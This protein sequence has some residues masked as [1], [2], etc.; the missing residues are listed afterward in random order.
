MMKRRRILLSV[1]LAVMLLGVWAWSA[2]F[3]AATSTDLRAGGVLVPLGLR[4][5]DLRGAYMDSLRHLYDGG[6]LHWLAGAPPLSATVHLPSPARAGDFYL[7]PGEA[8]TSTA[9]LYTAYSLSGT[10]P[11][12]R[13][14]ALFPAHVA[15]WRSTVTVPVAVDAGYVVAGWEIAEIRQVFDDALM[16]AV[17]Y[18]V[19]TEAQMADRLPAYDVLILPAFRS[20]ARDAVVQRL[21][22]G[23]AFTAWRD[24]VSRGG[25]IL[26]QG[27]AL[28]LLEAAGIFP[29]GTVNLDAPVPL[30][31]EDALVNRGRLRLRQPDSPLAYSWLTDTLYVLDDPLI[32]PEEPME[33]VAE[34]ANL[35]TE[36]V[37]PAL[38]RYPV[39][40][41]GQVIGIVGHPTDPARR[42]ELPLFMDA[43]LLACAGQ[44]DFYGDA[45]QTFNPHYPS[46]QIPLYESVP[47]SASLVVENLWDAPLT[48][49]RVT[50]TVAGGYT[51]L[52]A[53][54][55]PTPTRLMTTAA[56]ETVLLW[57]WPDLAAHQVTTLTYQAVTDPQVL[58]AGEGTF[59]RGRLAY[60]ATDGRPVVISHR[61]FRLT[62]LMAARL[63]GDRD[64]EADRHYIIPAQG[65]Y[66]D[67][68]FSLENKEETWARNLQ[69]TD[70]VL[71]LMPFV[72]TADQHVILSA[73]YG[74]TIWMRNEP[75]LWGAKY[76]L[77][78]G[79]TA[80][81][82]T[83][84]LADW[85]ALPPAE[86]PRCV[87]TSPYGIHIDP[88]LYAHTPITDYGSFIT[89]PPTYT[90]AITVTADHKL[91]LPCMP[92]RWD[93]GDFPPYWYEEPAVRFGIHSRELFGR[94][95][96]FHGTPREGTVVMPY[97]GGSLYVLAGGNPI[98]YD[99]YLEHAAAYAPQPPTPSALT[100]QD[101]WSRTHQ[102]ELRGSFYDVWDWDSCAT[103][104]GSGEQHAGIAITY[105]MWIDR[106]GDGVAETF[107]RDVPT[108]FPQTSLHI[109]GK[110]YSVA[111]AGGG[112]IPPGENLV[113]LPIFHGRGIRIRPQNEGWVDSYRSLAPGN[114][115]LI[116][117]THTAAY[118]TLLFHQDIP[119]GSSAAFA[120]TATMIP[121][122]N[123]NREGTIKIHDGGR[124]VYRQIAAGENRYEV[125]DSHV[126]APEGVSTD[127]EITKQGGPTLVS[128]YSDTLTFIYT[129][130]DRYD[131]RDF[132]SMYDPFFKS[133]GYDDL[134]WSVYVGGREQKTLFHS[135]VGAGGRTRIRVSLDNNT[136]VKLTHIQLIPE[137]PPGI[138]VTLLYTDPNTAPEPIWPELDFLNQSTVPDA[139]RSVWYFEVTVGNVPQSWWGT[140]I[141]IPFR[142]TADNFPAR[143]AYDEIPAARLALQRSGS[144]A[145]RTVS[146]AA[147]SVVLTDTLPS[148]VVLPEGAPGLV[149]TDTAA[150]R[151]LMGALDVDAGNVVSDTAGAF[152]A[153]LVPTRATAI[154]YVLGADGVLTFTLPA[155]LQHL[156][157]SG[158]PLYLVAQTKILR[159][160]HGPNLVNRGAGLSYTDPLGLVW[161][162]HTPPVTVEA[163]GAAV[164]VDYACD[165]GWQESQ[166]PASS[167]VAGGDGSCYIPD[168]GPSEVLIDVTAHN[169][170]DAIA[171]GVTMT[172]TLPDWVSA[173]TATP[174]W[175]EY[176]GRAVTWS[177][178]DLAPGQWKVFTIVLYVDPADG[179]GE[180]GESLP[181]IWRSDGVFRD[182]Y[183]HQLVRGQ[184]GDEFALRIYAPHPR[185]LVYLPLSLRNYDRLPDLQVL[186][187][188][189]APDNAADVQITI[190]NTG[191]SVARAF[192]VDVSLDPRVP[193]EVNQSCAELGCE[194]R[195]S[196]FVDELPAGQ[197]I[198]LKQGDAYEDTSASS[199]PVTY[200]LGTHTIWGY[201]D[202]WGGP[203]PWGG[204]REHDEHN[205]RSDPL[206]FTVP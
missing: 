200:T 187:L 2:Q 202:S 128:I 48:D 91:L 98:P 56:G 20:S 84:T 188:Q 55:H 195:L 14:Y 182:E 43:L 64:I 104:G 3:S 157:A 54:I 191:R 76:P 27:S 106:D 7:P 177:L 163:H 53:T 107:V 81:T 29:A 103:C 142:V 115:T 32:V 180:A 169:A 143:M 156:P 111:Q 196:W 68:A 183:S 58:A 15:V 201:V 95:V 158:S 22:S 203:N 4:Q 138:T 206:T 17:P 117:V 31:P 153:S 168:Y 124:L 80:P 99:A 160:Q 190:V 12:S 159:A 93:L 152:L 120:I 52:T 112:T 131:P 171:R 110:T 144:P 18:D 41:G 166:L 24:F 78:E 119:L 140:V 184:V 194:Y 50:E 101:V 162:E 132:A 63:V 137:P 30:L 197:T 83:L 174:P 161:R 133:W 40:T 5:A 39:G 113:A 145:P 42:D 65:V 130:Q 164:W 13:A 73:N 173:T 49:V 136:G 35:D 108:R 151:D 75:F 72:D 69:H 60:T 86:R 34:F 185:Y 204:V 150:I 61:P 37:Y 51:V 38:I 45:V 10:L 135:V 16:G 149:T 57:S 129:I 179:G 165:G 176:A 97:D 36:D 172:L 105:G 19:L 192:W 77:W 92:L 66:L 114:S 118:D 116:S 11:L 170:G 59:S 88:P 121:Y 155:S 70:W 46:H 102:L 26:A 167:E 141:T 154:D 109:L 47:L 44:A 21:Q 23:G 125:Y 33:V 71:L 74:E 94:E 28:Y 6:R 82:Q 193:P 175:Q 198:T 146:G 79:A 178:G 123:V 199:W 85:R 90:D 181:G 9:S 126:Q 100:Y 205:N 67:A 89:I 87:F 122:D 147:Q 127:L 1:V 186:A 139:G 62:A 8:L 96:R 25:T 134:V 148:N 189:A